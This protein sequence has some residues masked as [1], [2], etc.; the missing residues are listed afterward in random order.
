[1]ACQF[2]NPTNGSSDRSTNCFFRTMSKKYILLCCLCGGLTLSIGIL[3]LVTIKFKIK[4]YIWKLGHS[5]QCYSLLLHCFVL[6]KQLTITEHFEIYFSVLEIKN[7]YTRSSIG[8]PCMKMLTLDSN[9][10]SHN[11]AKPK[12]KK[13]FLILKIFIEIYFYYNFVNFTKS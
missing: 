7:C 5:Y 3:Y 9:R 1:M 6:S 11:F 2:N 12:K 4:F 8:I 13:I 10:C